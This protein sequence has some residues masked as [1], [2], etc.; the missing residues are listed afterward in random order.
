M[1]YLIRLWML[2]IPVVAQVTSVIATVCWVPF[3]AASLLY[4]NHRTHLAWP[5]FRECLTFSP[6]NAKNLLIGWGGEHD[7][8][9]PSHFWGDSAQHSHANF[10]PKHLCFKGRFIPQ[11]LRSRWVSAWAFL[12]H[13]C[14]FCLLFCFSFQLRTC[15]FQCVSDF[16]CV[17]DACH[18][19]KMQQVPLL[20]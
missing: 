1:W 15:A 20:L 9:T 17:L 6:F 7:I 10:L 18:T 14:V 4:S 13:S 5:S 12:M 8:T 16:F 2:E 19:E 11:F 3:W